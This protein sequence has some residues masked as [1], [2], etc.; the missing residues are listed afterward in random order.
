M[1]GHRPALVAAVEQPGGPPLLEPRPP[2]GERRL[3][4][5]AAQD[6]V[7]S[8]AVDQAGQLGVTEVPATGPGQ[9]ALRGAV[10]R[11]EPAARSA[12]PAAAARSASSRPRVSGPSH[13]AQAVTSQS[14][15]SV[16]APS[17]TTPADRASASQPVTFSPESAGR[18]GRGC[19]STRPWSPGPR[20]GPRYSRD[21]GDLGVERDPGPDVQ[22][23][24][25]DHQQVHA[26]G[27]GQHPVQLAQ[28]VVQVGDEEGLHRP[29]RIRTWRPVTTPSPRTTARRWTSSRSFQARFSP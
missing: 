24:A 29:G 18:R 28:V 2:V 14:P 9:R 23:V 6:Q 20:S 26:L 17:T 19:P 15:T 5:V 1:G 21:D 10:V 3:V 13:Q 4:D 22:Q 11:P 16:L 27:L 12:P 8:V 7:G 25:G